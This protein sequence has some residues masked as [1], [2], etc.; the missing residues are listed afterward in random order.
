M[1]VKCVLLQGRSRLDSELWPG[2]SRWRSCSLQ[3]CRGRWCSTHSPHEEHPRL[4]S[5]GLGSSPATHA[6]SPS[7]TSVRQRWGPAFCAAGTS[8]SSDSPNPSSRSRGSERL[9]PRDPESLSPMDASSLG[10]SPTPHCNQQTN[11]GRWFKKQM[12][13]LN[14]TLCPKSNQLILWR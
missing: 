1:R 6:D 13:Y 7:E 5:P 12:I 8:S 9:S 10:N 14:Q 3:C 2:W 4:P 11:S